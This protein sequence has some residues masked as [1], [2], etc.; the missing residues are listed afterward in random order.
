MNIPPKA[1]DDD[2]L[3]NAGV[4]E[5]PKAGIVLPKGEDDDAAPNVVVDEKADD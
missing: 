2:E 1:D 4:E 5:A 3:P